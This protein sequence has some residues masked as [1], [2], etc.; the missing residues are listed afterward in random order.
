MDR[1]ILLKSSSVKTRRAWLI[2]DNKYQ[3]EVKPCLEF[4]NI[5]KNGFRTNVSESEAKYL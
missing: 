3:K 4:H 2:C 1:M 5:V